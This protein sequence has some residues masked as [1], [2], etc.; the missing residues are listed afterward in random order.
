M[1]DA[2]LFTGGSLFSQDYL[3]EGI[4]RSSAYSA[5]DI[6]LLRDRLQAL[7]DAFPHTS[8]PK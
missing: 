7:L 5:V 8:R 1:I 4:T 6:T 2:A 3:V